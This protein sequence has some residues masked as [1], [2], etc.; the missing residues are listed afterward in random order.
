MMSLNRQA[1][2]F[3]MAGENVSNIFSQPEGSWS[4]LT[5]ML[6][7]QCLDRFGVAVRETE[8]SVRNHF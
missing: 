5:K 3:T 1:I 7:R 4:L 8:A 6:Y 2:L